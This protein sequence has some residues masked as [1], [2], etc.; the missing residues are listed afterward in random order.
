MAESP[1]MVM[2]VRRSWSGSAAWVRMLHSWRL[3]G[4]R[5]RLPVGSPAVSP[6]FSSVLQ[7]IVMV[8][9]PR[10]NG[11]RVVGSSAVVSICSVMVLRMHEWRVIMPIA[12]ARNCFINVVIFLGFVAF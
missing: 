11:S 1:G 10:G 4:R 5:V 3:S 12:K 9:V 8:S 7:E 6:A 2:Q